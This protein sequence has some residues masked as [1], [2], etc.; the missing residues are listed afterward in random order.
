MVLI[1]EKVISMSCVFLTWC[2]LSNQLVNLNVFKEKDSK[3]S[4]RLEFYLSMIQIYKL[5]RFQH[6]EISQYFVIQ[7]YN[8]ATTKKICFVCTSS[9][10]IWLD[11]TFFFQLKIF[12]GKICS[13]TI[14]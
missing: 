14:L 5:S 11:W 4:L 6:T 3:Y 10:Y 8:T 9:F 13:D 2:D 1:V 7:Y 12:S